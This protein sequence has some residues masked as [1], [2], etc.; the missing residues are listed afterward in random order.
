MYLGWPGF[1]TQ[2]VSD[3]ELKVITCRTEKLDM[4]IHFLF[5]FVFMLLPS[6]LSH[7]NI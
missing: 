6:F 2:P 3:P 4:V 5:A 1:L 7:E